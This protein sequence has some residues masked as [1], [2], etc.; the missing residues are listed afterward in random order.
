MTSSMG[1]ATLWLSRGRDGS[2]AASP[3]LSGY[4]LRRNVQINK[5]WVHKEQNHHEVSGILTLGL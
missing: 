4:I 5:I 1:L 3:E 2:R